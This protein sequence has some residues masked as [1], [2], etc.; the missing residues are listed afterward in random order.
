MSV[1]FCRRK[2]LGLILVKELVLVDPE[3]GLTAGMPTFSLRGV[4]VEVGGHYIVTCVYLIVPPSLTV[5]SPNWSSQFDSCGEHHPAVELFKLSP[6]REA[7]H[8]TLCGCGCGWRGY[9]VFRGGKGCEREH[10]GLG[11]RAGGL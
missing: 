1:C 11:V 7:L 3:E 9:L 6:C 8:P 5:G 2:L 10:A 4:G